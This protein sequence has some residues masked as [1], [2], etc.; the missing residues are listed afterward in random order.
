MNLGGSHDFRCGIGPNPSSSVFSHYLLKNLER[1]CFEENKRN[2]QNMWVY[3]T[4]GVNIRIIEP[5]SS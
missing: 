1:V 4:R 5:L 3:R 2:I